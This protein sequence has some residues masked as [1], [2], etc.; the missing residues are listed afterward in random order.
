MAMLSCFTFAA[1]AALLFGQP[2]HAEAVLPLLDSGDPRVYAEAVDRLTRGGTTA[3]P[4]LRQLIADEFRADRYYF[5][6]TLVRAGGRVSVAD[7]ERFLREEKVYWNNL[8]LN[9]DDESKVPQPRLRFLIDLLAHLER[10]GYRD[11]YGLVR[12][13]RDQFCDHPLLCICG[14]PVV[15][16]AEAILATK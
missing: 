2:V 6:D 5:L 3:L 9:L 7:L 8:G 11:E 16:I 15:G 13:V 4:V 1:A 12:A 10:F 14:T